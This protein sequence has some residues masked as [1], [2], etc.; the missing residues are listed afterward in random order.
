MCTA[1][2]VNIHPMC[3]VTEAAHTVPT[4]SI[5]FVTGTKDV[6]WDVGHR[7]HYLYGYCMHLSRLLLVFAGSGDIQGP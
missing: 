6:N 2:W 5:A 7:T 3:C 1:E 4:V